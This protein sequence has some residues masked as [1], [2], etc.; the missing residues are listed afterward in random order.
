MLSGVFVCVLHVCIYKHATF[1]IR[2]LDKNR[3]LI[4]QPRY[5]P[6][7][8]LLGLSVDPP[9]RSSLSFSDLSLLLSVFNHPHFSCLLMIKRNTVNIVFCDL[10]SSFNN[11][12]SIVSSLF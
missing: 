10:I 5:E 6:P 2:K 8:E 9:P 7:E 3:V 11:Y 12:W 1:F 4:W